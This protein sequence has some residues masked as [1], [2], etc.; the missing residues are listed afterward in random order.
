MLASSSGEE[1]ASLGG[2][3]RAVVAAGRAD[4]HQGGAGALHDRLDVGEVEVDQT[5]GG[6]QV[7]DALDTGEQHLVGRA[8][9]VEHADAAVA[10]RQQPVVRDDDQGVDLVAQRRRCRPRPGSARR[11]PS[12]VNGRVTT[13]IV[14]APSER[15]MLGDDGRAAG[16]GAAALAGGD[17]DHVGALEDLFDLLAVVLGGLAAHLGVGAGAEAAGELAADVELDVGVAHQQRLRVG[18]DRD[19]LDAL[20]TDLDHAVDG[21]DAAAA[22][23]DDLD[24]GEVVLR[25]CH[26]GGLSLADR[27]T[28]GPRQTLTLR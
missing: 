25:C 13:P 3:D 6:D 19:E 9:R 10:D 11:R 17:E 27:G 24:D 23:A 21:V 18:V 1:I 16:A 12:K 26:V 14:S 20:E 4:A 2:L 28:H 5:G 7:G 8:E 22:D 15:A